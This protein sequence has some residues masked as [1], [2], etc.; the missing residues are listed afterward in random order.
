MPNPLPQK[1]TTPRLVLRTANSTDAPGLLNATLDGY[2][3]LVKWLGRPATPPN[4][5]DVEQD[6]EHSSKQWD[7]RE[8]LRFLIVSK[9]D[10]RILGRMGFPPQQCDWRVPCF[11]ISYF[12][13]RS[14]NGSGYCTE[15][16]NALTRYAFGALKARRVEIKVDTDNSP[17]LRIPRKLGF[18]LEATQ[19]GIW[20]RPDKTELAT[21]QTFCVFDTANLPSLDVSW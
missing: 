14:A 15:A 16:V 20:P 2:E 11:G 5:R 19:K 12:I 17:S 13:A 7:S 18:E 8:F 6:I 21:F 9:A 3:D 10:D 4:L 1:I